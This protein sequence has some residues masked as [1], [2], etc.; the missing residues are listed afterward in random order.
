MSICP[1]NDIH[2]VY[3]DNELPEPFRTQYEEHLKS[4]SKCQKKLASLKA[5][6][7]LFKADSSQIGKI[8]PSTSESF[9]HLQ[10][11][12]SYSKIT[13]RSEKNAS[14][15]NRT[16]FAGAA[17]GIA[18]VAAFAVILPV[19]FTKTQITPSSQ[20]EFKPVARTSL[21]SAPSKEM[22]VDKS[23]YNA[24]LASFFEDSAS[25]S[26][27]VYSR[28]YG[29]NAQTASQNQDYS[30]ASYDIFS[31]L[32]SVMQYFAEQDS[33]GEVF[34]GFSQENQYKTQEIQQ[35]S[36]LFDLDS[37]YNYYLNYLAGN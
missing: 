18:A 2:S 33:S 24:N 7:S 12:L 21:Y 25:S 35:S 27:S 29:S 28:Q 23:L 9:K 14:R 11:Q 22:Q 1:E 15:K 34:T 26:A 10:A 13:G 31:L 6:S 36:F 20:A 4:C 30:F 8:T 3:L 19:S 17:A 5:M 16:L 37:A 32:P